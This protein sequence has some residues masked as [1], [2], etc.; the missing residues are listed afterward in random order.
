M[1]GLTVRGSMGAAS[2]TMHLPVVF[3]DMRKKELLPWASVAAEMFYD[4][5]KL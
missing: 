4:T 5:R 1:G 2:V 3:I